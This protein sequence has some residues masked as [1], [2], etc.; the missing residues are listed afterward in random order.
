MIRAWFAQLLS[1]PHL[2]GIPLVTITNINKLEAIQGNVASLCFN[3]FARQSSITAM[4]RGLPLSILIN[5]IW[6]HAN[7]WLNSLI[8]D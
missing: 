5:M 1:T 2:S 3:D 6:N 7:S 8:L 4:P